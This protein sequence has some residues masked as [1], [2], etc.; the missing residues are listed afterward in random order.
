MEL[1]KGSAQS[2]PVEVLWGLSLRWFGEQ[3]IRKNERQGFKDEENV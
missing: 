3:W 2:F 1:L